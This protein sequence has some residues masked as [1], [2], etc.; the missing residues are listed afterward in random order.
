MHVKLLARIIDGDVCASTHVPV[1]VEL[2]DA[3]MGAVAVHYFI[4]FSQQPCRV[5]AVSLILQMKK[6]RP[7]ETKQLHGERWT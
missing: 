6:L 4:S 1:C 7:R 5:G 3:V 2:C